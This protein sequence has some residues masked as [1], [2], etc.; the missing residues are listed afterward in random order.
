MTGLMGEQL[1]ERVRAHGG[2]VKAEPRAC[3]DR[4]GSWEG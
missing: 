1:Q 3:I 2:E 4:V